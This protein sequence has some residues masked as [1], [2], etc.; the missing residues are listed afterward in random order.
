MVF[1][2]RSGSLRFIVKHFAGFDLLQHRPEVVPA[3]LRQPDVGRQR[4]PIE[5]F[6]FGDG[7][8]PFRERFGQ[9]WNIM[10]MNNLL[11]FFKFSF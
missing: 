1:Q 7:L 10:S 3:C 11:I 4:L 6:G 5:T 2:H 9:S 8:R